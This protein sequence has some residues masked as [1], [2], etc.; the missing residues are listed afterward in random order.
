MCTRAV[1]AGG[2]FD[3][4]LARGL[5]LAQR[6]MVAVAASTRERADKGAAGSGREEVRVDVN[7]ARRGL[8]LGAK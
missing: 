1:H 6:G 7:G 3:K 5:A 8:V 2:L 4:R